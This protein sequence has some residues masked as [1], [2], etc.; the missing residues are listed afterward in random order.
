VGVD[1]SA[2]AGSRCVDHRAV[3]ECAGRRPA[4]AAVIR[5]ASSTTWPSAYSVPAAS[6]VATE[7]PSI[8]NPSGTHQW[9]YVDTC[10][11]R[12]P[13]RQ[14]RRCGWS[15]SR[16][17]ADSMPRRP[18][19]LDRARRRL[20]AAHTPRQLG[21]SS[22]RHPEETRCFAFAKTR[23]L[24]RSSSSRC[25]WRGISWPSSRRSRAAGRDRGGGWSGSPST[26][27]APPHAFA[28]AERRIRTAVAGLRP[29]R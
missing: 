22:D 4:P 21:A 18:E 25:G 15:R 2:S 5:P 23:L 14:Q 8:A 12:Q 6:H 24:A 20:D 10:R 28:R 3:T 13:V 19:R 17:M 9:V 7:Q 29:D 1:Q 11:S 27:R 26:R 16:V